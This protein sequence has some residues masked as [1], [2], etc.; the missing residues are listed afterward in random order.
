MAGLSIGRLR[1]S[2]LEAKR[3]SGIV[4]YENHS[5]RLFKSWQMSPRL[6]GSLDR[7]EAIS[8]RLVEISVP[9]FVF[10]ER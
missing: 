2:D 10:G 7:L 3:L 6:S 9:E 5:L 1:P 8:V 4:V